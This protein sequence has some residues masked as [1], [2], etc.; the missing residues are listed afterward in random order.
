[1]IYDF[2]LVFL[3]HHIDSSAVS[4][5]SDQNNEVEVFV[6]TS[7]FLFDIVCIILIDIKNDQLFRFM[8]CDLS[9][10]LTSDR[11]AASCNKDCFSFN[12][13]EDLIHIYFDRISSKQILD[14]N[15]FHL[16]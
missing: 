5:R 10:K 16:A 3:E 12:I 8:T 1:M 13:L 6:L 15:G 2:R 7:Q 9:A 11:T 4:D 14:C